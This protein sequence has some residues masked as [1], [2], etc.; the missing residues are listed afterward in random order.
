M[1]EKLILRL[2]QLQ[3]RLQR[4]NQ[5]KRQERALRLAK[6]ELNRLAKMRVL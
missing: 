2:E 3:A 1:L 4:Q 6:T 5:Q